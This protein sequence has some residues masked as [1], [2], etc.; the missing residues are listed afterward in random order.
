MNSVDQTMQAAMKSLLEI[1]EIV[2]RSLHENRNRTFFVN[3]HIAETKQFLILTGF[4]WILRLTFISEHIIYNTRYQR[5]GMKLVFEARLMEKTNVQDICMLHTF[6]QG[7]VERRQHWD[8]LDM[9]HHCLRPIED[10]VDRVQEDIH[11]CNDWDLHDTLTQ[12]WESPIFHTKE[13]CCI[14]LRY[15]WGRRMDGD[16]RDDRALDGDDLPLINKCR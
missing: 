1:S 15:N 9:G 8:T 7:F 16:D 2:G 5:M 10:W 13:Q 3:N 11:K 14:E 6:D 4:I 12:G